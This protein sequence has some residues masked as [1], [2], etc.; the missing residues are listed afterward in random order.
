MLQLKRRGASIIPKLSTVCPATPEPTHLAKD[1]M[2]SEVQFTHFAASFYDP[3]T[4]L[5]LLK[6]RVPT[7]LH[8][9]SFQLILSVSSFL[10]FDHNDSSVSGLTADSLQISPSCPHYKTLLCWLFSSLNENLDFCPG[11]EMLPALA[12]VFLSLN[13][14]HQTFFTSPSKSILH[15]NVQQRIFIL[16]VVDLYRRIPRQVRKTKVDPE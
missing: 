1:R 16:L 10:S 4:Y 13:A 5:S 12:I 3:E 9:L 11:F 14:Q 8:F 7:P 2:V 15:P 6:F